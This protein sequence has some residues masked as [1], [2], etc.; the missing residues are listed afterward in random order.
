[1]REVGKTDGSER[2][3]EGMEGG[4]GRKER[5]RRKGDGQKKNEMD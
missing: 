4:G 5:E 1:M 3:R 2:G